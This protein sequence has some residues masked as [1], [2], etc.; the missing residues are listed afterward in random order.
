MQVGEGNSRSVR[1]LGR[2]TIDQFP[3]LP[4]EPQRVPCFAVGVKLESALPDSRPESVVV[5]GYD[6]LLC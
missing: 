2:K 4:H 6:N 3:L 1:P 5:A